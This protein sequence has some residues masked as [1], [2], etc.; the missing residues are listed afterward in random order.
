MPRKLQLSGATDLTSNLQRTSDSATGSLKPKEEVDGSVHVPESVPVPVP[1][2]IPEM[3]VRCP[4]G[5]S[6]LHTESMIKVCVPCLVI[7]PICSN[8]LILI[9]E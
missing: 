1:I 9:D 7:N 8:F 5:S 6:S 3:K 2:R 4:C